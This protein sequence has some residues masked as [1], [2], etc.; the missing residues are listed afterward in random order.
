MKTRRTCIKFIVL[1]LL[2]AAMLNSVVF[3]QGTDS[4]R[5][6]ENNE[7]FYVG[8]VFTPQKTSINME[9]F[10]NNLSFTNGSA[11]NITVEGAFYFSRYAGISFGAG[12]SP[13]SSEVLLPIYSTEFSTVDSESES[14]E[15]QIEGISIT[16]IQKISFLSIPVSL[17]LRLPAGS[18]LGFFVN[19]GLSAEIPMV[20]K[21]DGTGT[22]TYDGYYPAYPVTLENIP[23]YGFPS[24]LLTKV[25]DE[26]E[27]KSFN[28]AL[29][30]SGGLYFYLNK[31]IQLALGTHF[32]RSLS[33][34]S[35]YNYDSEFSL[36]TQAEELNSMMGG[37]TKTGIQAFGISLGLRYFLE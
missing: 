22:F 28:A 29:T 34:I 30:V 36:T 1:P 9:G 6:F 11:I 35:G 12:L 25:S 8:L 7:K 32:S 19:A 20:K 14:Y 21:Y 18:S 23:A 15:M 10:S 37:S 5:L 17:A 24:D 13:Y 31:S 26:L 2:L 27:I 16:E 4:R 3:S 33:N